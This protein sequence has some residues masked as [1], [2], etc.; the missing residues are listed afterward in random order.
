MIIYDLICEH[1]HR[2]EG[3]FHDPQ[4]YSAQLERELVLCPQ[5]GSASVRKLPSAIA[6]A[7]QRQGEEADGGKHP[8]SPAGS[9]LSTPMTPTQAIAIYR[10]FVQAV[11]T[12]SEDVGPAFAAEARRMHYEEIPE[13]MIRGQASSDEFDELMEEGITV[14]RLPIFKEEDL[15]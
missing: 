9:H 13:R 8:V 11:T 3:W 15:N 7:K 12:L 10:Q 6:F 4:E 1:E 5:C 14:V 2:F